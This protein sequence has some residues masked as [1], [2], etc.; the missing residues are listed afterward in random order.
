MKHLHFLEQT[1]MTQHVE[2]DQSMYGIFVAREAAFYARE[3]HSGQK[4]KFSGEPYVLHCKRVALEVQR[5]T[6]DND[7]IAAAFLHD[8][9]ED[10]DATAEEIEKRFGQRVCEL[11]Q[12][13]TND[14]IEL[15]RIG[16]QA[17]LA[18][19][20]LLLDD[21][22]LLVKLADRF[23][24]IQDLTQEGDRAEWSEQYA[25]QTFH[26][27]SVLQNRTVLLTGAHKK[28]KEKIELLMESKGFKA[29]LEVV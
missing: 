24:N 13:L 5:Y 22:A 8:V 14:K 21:D 17:Y 25:K 10:T 12:A 4:R 27:L 11:V 2:T 28:L 23:D 9:L 18:K 16:K 7:T 15:K 1:N 26:I 19:K 3:K 20:V 29:K 6:A